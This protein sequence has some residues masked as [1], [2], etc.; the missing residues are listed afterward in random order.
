MP[1]ERLDRLA[2]AGPELAVPEPGEPRGEVE[3][4]HEASGRLHVHRAVIV[5]H[6]T[7]ADQTVRPGI[8]GAGA[9][10]PRSE[11]GGCGP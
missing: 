5:R 2:L 8:Q 9:R 1:E 10:S 4:L 3:S 7:P 6:G 11:R